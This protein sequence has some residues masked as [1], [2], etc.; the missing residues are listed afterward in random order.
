MKITLSKHQWEFIGE[1]TGWIKTSNGW[2][3][4]GWYQYGKDFVDLLK[5]AVLKG[6]HQQ[7]G[8]EGIIEYIKRDPYYSS[9]IEK[10][11]MNDHD[12][13]YFVH[14]SIHLYQ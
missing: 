3:N 1:K 13:G 7:I 6:I 10:E 8:L 14:D 9:L 12:L 5:P 2:K 4:G 11:K